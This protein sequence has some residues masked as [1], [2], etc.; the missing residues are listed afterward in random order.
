MTVGFNNKLYNFE[1]LKYTITYLYTSTIQ[2]F[3]QICIHN[4]SII[5]RARA[6]Y[7]YNLKTVL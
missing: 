1:F 2:Y 6:N 3:V 5:I 4:T 7:V